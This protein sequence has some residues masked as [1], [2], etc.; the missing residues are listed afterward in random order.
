MQ[1]TEI[2]VKGHIDP[3]WSDWVEGLNI[4]HIDQDQTLLSGVVVDQSTLFGILTKLRDMGLEIVSVNV[5]DS[6]PVEASTP[7]SREISGRSL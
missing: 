2:R 4:S 6:Q 1:N 7:R 3:T 5:S